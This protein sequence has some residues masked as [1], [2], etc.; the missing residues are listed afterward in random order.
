[1]E[2]GLVTLSGF[3]ELLDTLQWKNQTLKLAGKSSCSFFPHISVLCRCLFSILAWLEKKPGLFFPES[4]S[5]LQDKCCKFEI[6][7]IFLLGV[8][9][10]FRPVTCASNPFQSSALKFLT[11][12]ATVLNDS[13]LIS[14]DCSLCWLLGFLVAGHWSPYTLEYTSAVVTTLTM[15]FIHILVVWLMGVCKNLMVGYAGRYASKSYCK[16]CIFQPCIE[17]KDWI[18]FCMVPWGI[19]WS[20]QA[21]Q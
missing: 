18:T 2:K 20:R 14:D 3:W 11:Q 6:W 9:K 10:F 17:G 21:F 12:L 8:L 19:V 16:L 5:L 7:K 1:V 15:V 4:G 13:T